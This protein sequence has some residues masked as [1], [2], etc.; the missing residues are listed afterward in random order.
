MFESHLAPDVVVVIFLPA[1]LGDVSDLFW[2]EL[3]W[4]GVIEEV[5]AS[6]Y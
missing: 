3:G 5:R 6:E 2:L 4:D 1:G